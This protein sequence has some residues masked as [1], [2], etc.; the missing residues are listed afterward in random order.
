[1]RLI[2]IFIQHPPK[3]SPGK[4]APYV[5]GW[6]DDGYCKVFLLRVHNLSLGHCFL[7]TSPKKTIHHIESHQTKTKIREAGLVRWQCVVS[8]HLTIDHHQ[9]PRKCCTSLA[10]Y[11]R[12]SIEHPRR[13]GCSLVNGHCCARND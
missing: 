7:L 2:I 4:Q 11:Q 13:P 9:H 12:S 8:D 10:S 1:M 5:K 6:Q 3:N